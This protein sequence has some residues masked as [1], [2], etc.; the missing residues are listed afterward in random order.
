MWPNYKDAT[1]GFIGAAF[2]GFVTEE[3]AKAWLAE[4]VEDNPPEQHPE[5]GEDY[6]TP[7]PSKKTTS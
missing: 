2:K 1:G 5:H 7:P 6:S 3:D 4:E